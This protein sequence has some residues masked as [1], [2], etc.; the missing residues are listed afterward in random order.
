MKIYHYNEEGFFVGSTEGCLDPLETQKQ[1][2]PIY[3]IP[4]RATPESPPAASGHIA[5]WRNEEWDLIPDNRGVKYWLPNGTNCEI[6]QAGIDVPPDAIFDSPPV[7][8]ISPRW[9]GS[10]WQES[11]VDP[12][13]ALKEAL[14][15]AK[16]VEDIKKILA[17]FL[18]L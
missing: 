4:A 10:M 16:T 14:N 5:I 15:S 3:L 11:Y 18:Q 6:R 9:L 12:N 7:G 1:G 13:A 2:Q 8:M 17:D